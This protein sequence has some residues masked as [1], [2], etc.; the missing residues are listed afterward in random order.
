MDEETISNMTHDNK[1]KI[2]KS[3]N[4]LLIKADIFYNS[5]L[6][7]LRYIPIKSRISILIALRIY[8]AIGYKI[9]RTGTKFLKENIYIT[10]KE[11]MFLIIKSII[12]FLIFFILP[13]HRRKHNKCLHESLSGLADADT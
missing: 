12:E 8:Q 11:K 4:D 3:V 2:E 1:I 5:S 7:G 9:K 10:A 6:N 13:L